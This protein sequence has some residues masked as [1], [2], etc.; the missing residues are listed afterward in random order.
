MRDS[1]YKNKKIVV[2]A[3]VLNIIS[4]LLFV[5]TALMLTNLLNAVI[6]GNIDKLIKQTALL[7]LGWFIALVMDYIK[8]TTT[9]KAIARMNS[10]L[11]CQIAHKLTQ[12][13]FEEFNYEETG[14]YV[15]WLTND[16]TQIEN[17]AFNSFF[18]IIYQLATVIFSLCGLFYIHF[19]VAL[20]SILLLIIMSIV[21]KLMNKTIE[22]YSKNMSIEQEKFVKVIKETISGH[23]VLYSYNLLSRFKSNI[24]IRS[25]ILENA[26]YK[27]KQ[28]QALVSELIGCTNIVSQILITF[29]TGYLSVI[30]VIT[31]GN[32]LPSGNLAGSFFC[33]VSGILKCKTA[34]RSSKPILEKFNINTTNTKES[35]TYL[36]FSNCIELK[37]VSFSY[38]NKNVLKNISLTFKKN[39][40][41]AITGVS[42]SGKSTLIKLILGYLDDYKGSIYIDDVDIKEYNQQ[43]IRE[44][45]AYISQ[46]V[47]VFSGT[48]KDN[49]TL[50]ENFTK[51]QMDAALKESCLNDFVSSLDENIN[52]IISEDGNNISGGQKQRIAI[53]RALI[54]HKPVIIL[55]EGT[56]ALDKKNAVEVETTLLKNPNLTV[57]LI[58]HHLNEELIDNFDRI[59][60]L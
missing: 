22:K 39:K 41:Y 60:T 46:N 1:L 34:I 14:S 55:D 31:I 50:Y 10:T 21:P 11:R 15:S 52:T 2:I 48:I 56:S 28:K 43:S 35:S 30:K 5:I 54:R 7:L 37:N 23:E 53:A 16:I 36:H 29:I 32:I 47:Y 40:K 27:F 4:S 45:I 13:N 6:E 42:G 25:N 49:I 24:S 59:I 44:N 18:T 20:A 3:S 8:E 17:L 12:M 57:I 19:W 51:E 33:A 58:T 38:T 9:A 26:K